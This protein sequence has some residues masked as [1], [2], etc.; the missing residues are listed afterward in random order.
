[1]SPCPPVLAP[2]RAILKTVM[3]RVWTAVPIVVLSPI[4]N[5]QP[6][7]LEG[8][9]YGT[10]FDQK[11]WQIVGFQMSVMPARLTSDS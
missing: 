11:D 2:K 8:L 1:M 6:T 3:E 5:P 7:K 10:L 4:A 9:F